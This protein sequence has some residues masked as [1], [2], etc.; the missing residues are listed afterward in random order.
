MYLSEEASSETLLRDTSH[1]DIL[2]FACH[3]SLEDDNLERSGIELADRR[4]TVLDITARLRV[5]G[6]QLIYLSSC[7]SAQTSLERPEELGAI[8]RAFFVAGARSMIASL[9]AVDDDASAL[10]ADRFYR[11]CLNDNMALSFAF[12]QAMLDV[13]RADP[14]PVKWAPF[15]L[16]GAWHTQIA[17]APGERGSGQSASRD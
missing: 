8:A 6:T 15:V 7:D 12:R 4:L 9:W 1:A 14:D 16:I 3:S 2:H 10:F 5:S 17:G 11:Y 13:Q